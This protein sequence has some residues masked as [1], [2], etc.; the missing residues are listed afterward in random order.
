MRIRRHGTRVA[1][2]AVLD[3]ALVLAFVL[4]GRASHDESPVLGALVTLW[5]FAAGLTVGWL[6]ARVWRAPVLVVRAG[7]PIW[8]STVVVGVL[9]RAITGQGVQ[10][11]FA[12]VATLVLGVF[13]LGWRAIAMFVSR[14]D[15]SGSAA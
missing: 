8:L 7:I 12:I 15:R 9:L 13:L 11:S 4:I 14:S 3:L 2:S 1:A 5:P 6:L 10:L